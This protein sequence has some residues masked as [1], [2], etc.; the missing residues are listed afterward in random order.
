MASGDGFQAPTFPNKGPR[1]EAN[2]KLKKLA[3]GA[4]VPVSPTSA[5]GNFGYE[6]SIESVSEND[7]GESLRSAE[8][9]GLGECEEMDQDF[10]FIREVLTTHAQEFGQK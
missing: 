7:D 10:E 9:A 2:S 5:N 4:R 6:N 3:S 8:D 1:F